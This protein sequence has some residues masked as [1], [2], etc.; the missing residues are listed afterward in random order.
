MAEEKG[1][2]T[3]NIEI[4]P[5]TVTYEEGKLKADIHVTYDTDGETGK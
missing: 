3:E 2:S 5:S 1:E 4:D